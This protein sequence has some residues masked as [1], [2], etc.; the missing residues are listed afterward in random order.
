[1]R[2]WNYGNSDLLGIEGNEGMFYGANSSLSPGG[3]LIK[4]VLYIPQINLSDYKDQ[5]V[6]L[7]FDYTLRVL[8]N[9]D[10]LSVVYRNMN[11]INWNKIEDLPKSGS[12][13]W[14]WSTYSITLP[15]ELMTDSIQLGF[16]YTNSKRGRG[17]GIDN[18]KLL[19]NTTGIEQTGIT[20]GALVYPN[21]NDGT[22]NIRINLDE[23]EETKISLF[24]ISGKKVFEEVLH[25]E[26]LE[27]NRKIDVRNYPKGQ[28]F[29][30]VT[31]RLIDRGTN[32]V[33][34]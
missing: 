32:I 14:T 4:D 12:G 5:G 13:D 3:T 28:Y 1:M 6:N 23:L 8:R 33:I 31:N 10:T 20:E 29:L 2:G 22:F 27:I 9:N 24:D 7:E 30:R 11:E 16:S 25:P 26:D 17:A 15:Q 19:I 34:R 18:V 21:P